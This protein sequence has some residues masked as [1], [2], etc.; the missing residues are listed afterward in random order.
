MGRLP[1]GDPPMLVRA[2]GLHFGA[3]TRGPGRFCF[4][5]AFVSA[6]REG[7]V[8]GPVSVLLHLLPHEA[9]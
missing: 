7:D 1:R 3:G 8:Q 9:P 6:G 5:K 4:T 2:W